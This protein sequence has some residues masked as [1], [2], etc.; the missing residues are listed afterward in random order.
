M[1]FSIDT[2]IPGHD[3]EG[4]VECSLTF[5]GNP[6]IDIMGLFHGD[7]L[8][9]LPTGL[10]GEALRTEIDAWLWNNRASEV[11]AECDWRFDRES[12]QR[13]IDLSRS[14]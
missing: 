4:E 7:G 11:W 2:I 13:A 9:D 5:E 3:L 1:R 12:E 14:A 6:K 10:V 8:V